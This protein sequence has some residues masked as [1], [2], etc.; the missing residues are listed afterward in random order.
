MAV[1]VLSPSVT[2]KIGSRSPK[3]NQLFIMS[4]CYIHANLVKIHL[5]VPE[6]LSR[7]PKPNQLFTM[8]QCYIHANLVKIWQLVHQISCKQESDTPTLMLTPTEPAPKTKCPPLL[9]RGHI[10]KTK[11]KSFSSKFLKKKKNCSPLP[12]DFTLHFSFSLI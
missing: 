10:I 11:I 7:S 1:K 9:R 4:K 8:S 2:L 12:T 6:I 3:P 5:L